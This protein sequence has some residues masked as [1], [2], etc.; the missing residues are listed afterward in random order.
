MAPQRAD[1]EESDDPEY[2]CSDNSE[3]EYLDDDKC[4]R[5]SK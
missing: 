2:D 1:V 3:E 4:T 5:L